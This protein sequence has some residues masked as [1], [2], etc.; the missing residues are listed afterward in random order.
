ML[1]V[2]A[3][4]RGRKKALTLTIALMA[5]PTLVIAV[6]PTYEIIGIAA[7]II[8]VLARMMQGFAAGGESGGAMAYLY[9]IAPEGRRGLYTSLWY[10]TVVVGIVSATLLG[11]ILA[12]TI[13]ADGLSDWGWRIPFF[14]G[15]AAGLLAF[16][17]RSAMT[18]T[19]DVEPTT[20][21][22]PPGRRIGMAALLA[23]YPWETFRVILLCAGP[24]IAWVHIRQLHA[25]PPHQISR[26]LGL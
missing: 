1:G 19:A 12:Q 13:T 24:A 8:L 7:P 23:E 26:A 10:A 4:C 5:A 20:A 25:H 2:Y 15:G 14:I 9:E 18:E 16:W 3:D 17:V 21:D 11:Y 6:S 22:G